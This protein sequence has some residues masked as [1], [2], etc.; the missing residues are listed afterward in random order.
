MYIYSTI[1]LNSTST[2]CTKNPFLHTVC[3]LYWGMNYSG[4]WIH[5]HHQKYTYFIVL[6]MGCTYIIIKMHLHSQ[7]IP[8]FEDNIAEKL[9]LGLHKYHMFHC[10]SH[11]TNT[12]GEVLGHYIELLQCSYQQ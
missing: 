6:A 7:K 1:G 12:F 2:R 8:V 5:L 10:M 3:M 9:V 4:T 11:S